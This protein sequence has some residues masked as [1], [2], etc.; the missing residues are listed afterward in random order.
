MNTGS[1][2]ALK[3]PKLTGSQ[4]KTN[5]YRQRNEKTNR[6]MQPQYNDNNR[7][8]VETGT[9]TVKTGGKG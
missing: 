7:D 3:F 6:F 9:S 5:P 1:E 4:L 2:N 8:S